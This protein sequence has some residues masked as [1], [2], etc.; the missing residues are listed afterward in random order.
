MCVYVC[1]CVFV[2]VIYALKLETSTKKKKIIPMAIA[3]ILFCVMTSDDLI[4]SDS[5]FSALGLHNYKLPQPFSSVKLLNII[6]EVYN[7][8]IAKVAHFCIFMF[9]R[10]FC[11][12]EEQ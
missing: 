2:Q 9:L 12:L 1:T 7:K 3:E 6:A 5:G 4:N 8:S 11:Y 10:A